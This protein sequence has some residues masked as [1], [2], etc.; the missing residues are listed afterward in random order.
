MLVAVA[1]KPDSPSSKPRRKQKGMWMVWNWYPE[2]WR[3]ELETAIRLENKDGLQHQM[4]AFC[5]QILYIRCA[6]FDD[7]RNKMREF[8]QRYPE[9]DKQFFKSINH[10]DLLETKN[11]QIRWGFFVTED[12][13]QTKL[14]S[15]FEFNI[16]ESD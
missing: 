12:A 1:E 16:T 4:N 11:L 13:M 8:L 2:N 15:F 7:T 14:H 6:L 10:S 3:Y 9:N 5:T